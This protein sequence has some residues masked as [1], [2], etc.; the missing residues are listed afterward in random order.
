MIHR[1]ASVSKLI[2]A[3]TNSG[4]IFVNDLGGFGDSGE[5]VFDLFDE[6]TRRVCIVL[7]EGWTM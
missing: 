5:M 2:S 1:F 7:R 3:K 6:A 4:H